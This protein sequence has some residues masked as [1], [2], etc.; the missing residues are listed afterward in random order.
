MSHHIIQQ[1][2]RR[3]KGLLK[4]FVDCTGED[5]SLLPA[6]LSS[7]RPALH[8][9]HVAGCVAVV[10]LLELEA[11]LQV[12]RQGMNRSRCCLCV[13]EGERK[14]AFK[15]LWEKREG[16]REEG[17]EGGREGHVEYEE[18]VLGREGRREGGG[19]GST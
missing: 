9:E 18:I 1:G 19:G 13:A 3:S 16:G 12:F 4:R 2:Q 5:P 10:F 8:A 6:L 7:L 17:R 11:A 14:S 15:F